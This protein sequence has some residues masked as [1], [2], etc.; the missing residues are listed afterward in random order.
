MPG[1][2]R[3]RHLL[4]PQEAIR[5]ANVVLMGTMD[6]LM[7]RTARDMIRKKNDTAF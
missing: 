4:L 2:S 1:E 5:Y 7:N 3:D 6:V